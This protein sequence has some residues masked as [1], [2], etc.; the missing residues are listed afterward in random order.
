MGYEPSVVTF[1]DI[2]GFAD[3]VRDQSAEEIA[4]M[5]DA[6]GETA[7]RPLDNEENATSVVSFSDSVIRARP[8]G[9]ETI[10]DALLHEI[11]DLAASQWQL[12][13]IGM[14]I[15]GGTTVGD[16]SMAEGRAFGPAFV[17]AYRLES[18]L[19]IS[20]RIVIDPGVIESIRGHLSAATT[21]RGRT[22]LIAGLRD[23]IR[24]GDDGVWFVDYVNSVHITAGSDFVRDGL[25]AMRD[26]VIEAARKFEKQPLILP[27]YLWQIR[28][29][30][31][32]ARRLF[33]KDPKLRIKAVDVPASDEF[34]KPPRLKTSRARRPVAAST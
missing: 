30:N 21:G 12:L 34:L 11:Q 25:I 33:P 31:Q 22:E 4:D 16:V 32:S 15:R 20:P 24:L 29:H 19:A 28:Y 13:E 18:S 3:L 8:V 7:A 1:V 5:L 9:P 2:L 14:L 17:R 10:Y 27:K 6:I 26:F 23:H